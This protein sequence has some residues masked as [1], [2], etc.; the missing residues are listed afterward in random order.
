MNI[1]D[2][3]KCA[4]VNNFSITRSDFRNGEF[5]QHGMDNVLIFQD[6]RIMNFSIHDLLSD[7]YK[8]DEKQVYQ[9]QG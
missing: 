9:K 3:L 5:L 7:Q 6:G 8:M 2:A 1:V 4:R